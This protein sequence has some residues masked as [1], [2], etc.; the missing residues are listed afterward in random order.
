MLSVS[1]FFAS[2][3]HRKVDR[4]MDQ[5]ISDIVSLLWNRGETEEEQAVRDINFRWNDL[6]TVEHLEE[7]RENLDVLENKS[8]YVLEKIQRMR[9]YV[10]AEE[11]KMRVQEGEL[12]VC[13]VK[14]LVAVD[15]S[16]ERTRLG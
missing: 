3:L 2:V 15:R 11:E 1:F 4:I 7:I 12:R 6:H 8:L 10:D 9:E 14:N 13:N 16:T 5:E